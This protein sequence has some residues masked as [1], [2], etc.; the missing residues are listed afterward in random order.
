MSQ[1]IFP[2]SRGKRK[3][4]CLQ[5]KGNLANPPGPLRVSGGPKIQQAG[6]T[7]DLV[8]FLALV[9]S[10]RQGHEEEYGYERVRTWRFGF[11]G[12][13]EAKHPPATLPDAKTHLPRPFSLYS[14]FDQATFPEKPME[15][16]SLRLS[17]ATLALAFL[18]QL[19]SQAAIIVTTGGVP[20]PSPGDGL[21]SAVDGAFTIDF[22]S[23]DVETLGTT[24]TIG[25]ATFSGLT[26]GP[27]GSISRWERDSGYNVIT[28]DPRGEFRSGDSLDY[29]FLDE[30]ISSSV[31]ID[32]V[33]SMQYVGMYLGSPDTDNLIEFFD[34]ENNLLGS[35]SPPASSTDLEYYNF[36]VEAGDAPIARVVLSTGASG[37]GVD[38]IAYL[39]VPEPSA[40]ILFGAAA[41][42]VLIFRRRTSAARG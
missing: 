14:R 11:W 2:A 22:N 40:C 23:I 29:L 33:D 15:S 27:D 28:W 12:P 41:F 32:F 30:S 18:F 24:Y 8:L 20:V 6:S 4:A 5:E 36:T 7:L 35:Y 17:L 42:G 9:L 26:P 21:M 25:A 37:M 13:I 16:I 31:V 1:A 3:R 10:L 39:A 38:N 34:A 19:P